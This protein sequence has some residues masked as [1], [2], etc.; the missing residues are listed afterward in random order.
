MTGLRWIEIE[1]EDQD[2]SRESKV[3]FCADLGGFFGEQGRD[4]QVFFVEK[5]KISQDVIRAETGPRV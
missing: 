5:I 2:V 3:R 1:I 4:V